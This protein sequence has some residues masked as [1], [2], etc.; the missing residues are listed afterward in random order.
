MA[1]QAVKADGLVDEASAAG[2]GNHAVTVHAKMLRLELVKVKAG[3]ERELE[4][5]VLNCSKVRPRRALGV[6]AWRVTWP[7]VAR[8]PT[9][10]G[11]PSV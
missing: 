9:P 1:E 7:L 3:P 4:D 8:E 2:G 11:D 10:H 6:W 5:F